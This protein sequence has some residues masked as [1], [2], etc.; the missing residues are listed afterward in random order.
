MCPSDRC[1]L[2]V[3]HLLSIL[4]MP[5]HCSEG[6]SG[7]TGSDPVGEWCV[8]F[9]GTCG[10]GCSQTGS[11]TSASLPTPYIMVWWT[12]MAAATRLADIL[13]SA[14]CW[15][16]FVQRSQGVA[17]CFAM[18]KIFSWGHFMGPESEFLSEKE[19]NMNY[20]LFVIWEPFPV[21]CNQGFWHGSS[22]DSHE[23]LVPECRSHMT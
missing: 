3:K 19:R 9:R 23:I 21:L 11:V 17:F 13:V 5:N 15:H 4:T 22:H 20:A 10:R 12:S 1:F 18:K 8:V 16:T 7:C 14:S 2:V 6:G